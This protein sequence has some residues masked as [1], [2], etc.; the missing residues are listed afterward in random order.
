M[1]W[2]GIG[3]LVAV[4]MGSS[5]SS[6]PALATTCTGASLASGTCSV[7]GGTTGDGVDL[8]GD[9]TDGGMS[10]STSDDG[11]QEC[12]HPVGD[13]CLGVSPPT[14]TI[15]ATTVHDI[16]SFHP[17]PPRQFSEPNG[18]T[19]RGAPTNFVTSAISHVVTGELLGAQAEVRFTPVSVTRWFGDG[20]SRRS[21]SLGARWS[22]LGQRWWTRTETSHS[23]AES[24]HVTI[25]ATVF[26][27]AEFR[28]GAQEWRP[29]D[30]WVFVRPDALRLV[31]FDADTVLVDA[32][33]DSDVVGCGQVSL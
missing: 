12:P 5:L 2:R 16:A 28:F 1:V 23:F 32:P 25:H 10:G 6:P 9:A 13:R 26:Y 31:V 20:S 17:E 14:D 27:R 33:C 4:V 19:L 15:G 22:D 3:I 30:G 29:L 18:W 21:V 8:W 11:S 24:G 7:G